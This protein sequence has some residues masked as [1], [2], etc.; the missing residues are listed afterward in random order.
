M[1]DGSAKSRKGIGA[2]LAIAAVC[3]IGTAIWVVTAGAN[4]PGKPKPADRPVMPESVLDFTALFSTHCAACHGANGTLGPAPPLNDPLFRAIVP[5]ETLQEVISA[6]RSETPMPGF[7]NL[8]GGRLT[9][10]QIQV[11][12]FQIKGTK[13]RIIEPAPNANEETKVV[14]DAGGIAPLWGAVEPAPLG[15]PSYLE[16]APE[17][18]DETSKSGASRSAVFARACAGCHG[19]NGEG[20]GAGAINSP[21]FLALASNQFLRRNIITGR[22]DLGMPDYQSARKRPADFKPLT[23]AEIDEIVALIGE[24]RNPGSAAETAH[25]K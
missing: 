6:G 16:P 7:D 5:Q 10:A 14:E 3:L 24:W 17:A 9:A 20:A 2:S 12:V 15:T 11:L 21:Q 22:P 19:K 25:E 8:H 18:P 23:S 1:T 13:Y 4:L